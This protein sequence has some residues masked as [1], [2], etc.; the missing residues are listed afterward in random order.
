MPRKVQSEL[1]LPLCIRPVCYRC[2]KT[3]TEESEKNNCRLCFDVF[4]TNCWGD[5]IHLPPESGY[6]RPQAVCKSCMLLVTLFPTF[7][8]TIHQG[9]GGSLLLPDHY[10]IVLANTY[11]VVEHKE[12]PGQSNEPGNNGK[13]I[14]KKSIF[15]RIFGGENKTNE[16]QVNNTNTNSSKNNRQQPVP[17]AANYNFRFSEPGFDSGASSSKNFTDGKNKSAASSSSIFGGRLEK[18][19]SGKDKSTDG[20]QHGDV[21][22]GPVYKIPDVNSTK[23]HQSRCEQMAITAFRPLQPDTR[24]CVGRDISIPFR[25]IKEIKFL[26][27][28]RLRVVC[29]PADHHHRLEDA[30]LGKGGHG[31]GGLSGSTSNP[32]A[33]DRFVDFMVVHKTETLVE[34]KAG[35]NRFSRAKNNGA[36]EADRGTLDDDDDEENEDDTVSGNHEG[37]GSSGNS[38]TKMLNMKSETILT[39]DPRAV[40]A[41]YESLNSFFKHCGNHFSF[42]R[43]AMAIHQDIFAASRDASATVKKDS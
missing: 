13:P 8:S 43:S 42:S 39:V 29:V 33:V 15:S 11:G 7:T 4:C 20:N 34:Q 28:E 24:L 35:R 41:L 25:D 10:L 32:M 23:F 12:E 30:A 1:F 2:G 9:G 40:E 6:T 5:L 16:Q 3:F 36:R 19:S 14:Q 22:P 31:R 17:F 37:N 38:E 21:D 18:K 26:G 27:R